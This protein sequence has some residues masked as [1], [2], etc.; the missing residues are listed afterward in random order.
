VLWVFLISQPTGNKMKT[1]IKMY[2]KEDGTKVKS[3]VRG[4]NHYTKTHRG[5][6]TWKRQL[7]IACWV[8]ISICAVGIMCNGLE[9]S[10]SKRDKVEAK[11]Q[12]VIP[13]V[14]P[15]TKEQGFEQVAPRDTVSREGRSESVED[16][17]RKVFGA[18]A[19][20]AL[21][22]VKCESSFKT[23]ALGDTNTPHPSAGLFQ[24]R[25]L[26]ER[27]ITKEQM[28]NVDENINYAKM[29]FDKHGWKPWSCRGVIK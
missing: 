17:I 13:E 19:E 18:Q 20:N 15:L 7:G 3:H 27:Q 10:W 25:L 4:Q 26:P 14:S 9:Y 24:I 16:K 29:L 5:V 11:T 21:R 8:G 1:K 28:F 2:Y 23:D 6:P 12:E 22:I